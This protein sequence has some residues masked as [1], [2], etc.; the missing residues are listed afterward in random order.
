MVEIREQS[1]E[2]FLVKIYIYVCAK[3]AMYTKFLMQCKSILLLKM[4]MKLQKYKYLSTWLY[5]SKC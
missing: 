2:T 3:G 1:Q 5:I 4:Y